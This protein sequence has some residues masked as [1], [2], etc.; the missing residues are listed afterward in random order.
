MEAQVGEN[1]SYIWR[2]MVAAIPVIK[3]GTKWVVGNGRSIKIWGEKWIPS[4]DSG[5]IVTPRTSMDSE[6]KVASL[7][8]Q[9]RAEWDVALIRRSFLPY[10][11]KAILSIPISPMNP[12]DSQVWAKSPNDIFTVKSAHKVAAKYL[13]DLKGRKES[14][15]SS[16]NSKMTAIWKVVWNLKCPNKIKHFMWRAC[17]NVLPTKQCLLHRKVLTE[18]KCDFC[19]ESE[20]SGHALWGCV[21]AKETW[22]ETKF[23]LDKLIQPPKEFLD[24]VW[25]LLES[26]REMNW[27]A[28]AITA[29]GLWNNRKAV[30]HG[31]VCKRGKTIAG[32]AQKYEL[33]LCSAIP[34]R[35][36]GASF[37]PRLKHWSLPPKGTYKV[38]TDAAVFNN[39]GSCGFGVVIR[40]DQGEMMGDLCKKV[41]LPLGA[42]K[43]EAKAKATEAGIYL[44]WDLNLKDIVVEGDSQQVI[45]ALNGCNP[46][47][48]PIL[49]IVEGLKRFLL[50]FNS[51]KAMH[52]RRNTNEAAHLLAKNAMNVKDS[53]IWVE[54]IP[55]L[56]EHQ[57]LFDVSS[58]DS[59]P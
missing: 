56:I 48:L 41:E 33:E 52:T 8:V 44:A 32:E 45:Q 36:I 19:G 23:R 9:E 34:V 17:R 58:L 18:D 47:A 10:E 53:V 25:L 39:R 1:P 28:F 13:D 51:W 57:I 12:S 43:A 22:A 5:R 4:S 21:I 15:G 3:E 14:P 59:C 49:K 42:I 31:E 37:A 2:S 26:P 55:P 27:D 16:D 38:N 29:W 11:A 46:P 40:N 6:A 54:D 7:I 35:C 24:M 50:Q 30:R 20:S